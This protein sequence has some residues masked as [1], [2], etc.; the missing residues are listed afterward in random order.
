MAEM[1]VYAGSLTNAVG[2]SLEPE[3]IVPSSTRT[4]H[5]SQ[6]KLNGKEWKDSTKETALK[7]NSKNKTGERNSG[8]AAALAAAAALQA[9]KAKTKET[10][11][12]AVWRSRCKEL[13][14][15]DDPVVRYSKAQKIFVS[16]RTSETTV[17]GTEIE[18]YAVNAL[19]L[20]WIRYCQ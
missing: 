9:G 16:L 17:V 15:E 2:K 14:E 18:L 4:R 8:K 12:L 1:M 20:I 11:S 7:Q 6:T 19:T 10:H 5:Q 13:D 3:V